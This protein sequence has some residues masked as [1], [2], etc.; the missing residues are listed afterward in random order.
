[1]RTSGFTNTPVSRLLLYYTIAASVLAGIADA[2]YLFYILVVPHLWGYGQLWRVGA[3]QVWRP[4]DIFVHRSWE[5]RERKS[6]RKRG[7]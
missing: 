4:R 2:K 1:M 6:M 7:S 3:W 5:R